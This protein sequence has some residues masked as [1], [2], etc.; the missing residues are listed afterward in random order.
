LSLTAAGRREL[1]ELMDLVRNQDEALSA[2][3]A[4]AERKQLMTLLARLT[5]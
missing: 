3:L 1:A 2:M 5:V 4:P